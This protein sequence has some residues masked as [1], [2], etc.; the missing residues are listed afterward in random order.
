MNMPNLTGFAEACYDDSTITELATALQ[1]PV[2]DNT[3]CLEWCIS[4]E[5]WR[6]AITQAL[7]AKVAALDDN[8]LSD[9]LERTEYAES[10]VAIGTQAA[11]DQDLRRLAQREHGRR[12]FGDDA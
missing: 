2:A 11:I 4:A 1:Q 8:E 7:D 3:D 6:D 5:E 12:M 9:I 10:G